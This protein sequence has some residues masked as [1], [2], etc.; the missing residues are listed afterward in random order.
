MKRYLLLA[1]TAVP[2]VIAF[3]S[4]CKKAVPT[5]EAGVTSAA[6]VEDAAPPPVAEADAAPAPTLTPTHV[7]TAA[8]S[9]PPKEGGPF[10]GSYTCFAGMTV[11]QSGNNVTARQKPGDTQ[12]YATMSCTASGDSCE[13]TTT[14]YTGGKSS[15][16]KKSSM[17]R[18]SSGDITYKAEGESPTLCHKK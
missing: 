12:S 6:V 14:M 17:K 2:V 11:T 7:A 3:G 9:A 18:N 15:G 1:L 8:K 4:G 10:Q 16:T 13:G 5:V